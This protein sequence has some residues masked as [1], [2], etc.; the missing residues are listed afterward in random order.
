MIRFQIRNLIKSAHLILR[1][2]SA[3]PLH[4]RISPE[5]GAATRGDDDCSGSDR[6]G[7]RLEPRS[8]ISACNC[9]RGCRISRSL[10]AAGALAPA[11]CAVCAALHDADLGEYWV[12]SG[13]WPDCVVQLTPH[14]DLMATC[15]AACET[16]AR[17]SWG[18]T[19]A[20]TAYG[21]SSTLFGSRSKLS[22]NGWKL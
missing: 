8:A 3:A 21:I 16:R 6:V 1:T 15:A 17:S 10:L 19:D 5:A 4:C 7:D 2:L 9:L 12:K 18:Q 11:G 14:C 20:R 22:G 13:R